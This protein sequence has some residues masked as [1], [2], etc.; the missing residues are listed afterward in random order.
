MSD[1]RAVLDG[2]SAAGAVALEEGNSVQKFAVLIVDA[3]GHAPVRGSDRLQKM[4]FMASKAIDELGVQCRFEPGK[5]G[6]HSEA[7]GEE[8]RAWPAWDS[9]PTTVEILPSRPKARDLQRS[10]RRRSARAP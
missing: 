1:G 7:V 4:M 2:G 8:L 6:P 3:D 9:C 10:S 5:H